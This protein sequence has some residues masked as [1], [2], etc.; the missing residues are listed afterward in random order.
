MGKEQKNKNKKNKAL[1]IKFDPQDRIQFLKNQGKKYTKQE[2][3]KYL[4][5][6]KIDAK[7]KEQLEHNKMVKQQIE[8]KYEQLK[9]MKKEIGRYADFD[10][11]SD[12]SIKKF[13]GKLPL[14]KT[15]KLTSTAT[16]LLFDISNTLT[17]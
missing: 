16:S 9:N 3:K 12:S 13:K 11:S 5:K 7:R 6:K 15:V 14:V 10:S 1:K 17:S 8:E 2:R 4:E